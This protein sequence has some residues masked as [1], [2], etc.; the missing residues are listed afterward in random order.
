MID[1][2]ANI[3]LFA[4]TA[5]ASVGDSGRVYCFEPDPANYARLTRNMMISGH[6][7]VLPL[8][9]ALGASEG[10]ATFIVMPEGGGLS[11]FAPA[12]LDL[13]RELPVAV[14]RLDDIVAVEDRSRVRLLKLDVEGAESAAIEGAR[15]IIRASRP[16]ILVEVEDGHLRRQ[17][18]SAADLRGAITSFGYRRVAGVSP[19]N[20]LFLPE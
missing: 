10:V 14:R 20:E 11:S 5:A 9:Y 12:N 2:G 8:P 4:L 17:G 13:G 1:G 6:L 3:G 15:E 7:N 18:S 16:A 19:P